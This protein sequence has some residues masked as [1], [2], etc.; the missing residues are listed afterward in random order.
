[1]RVQ[2]LDK[3][4]YKANEPIKVKYMEKTE[5]KSYLIVRIAT[6]RLSRGS[7][8]SKGALKEISRLLSAILIL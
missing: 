3:S 2:L 6:L 7:Q 5:S 1:M 8:N 4:K